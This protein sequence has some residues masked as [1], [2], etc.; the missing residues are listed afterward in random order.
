[1]NLSKYAKEQTRDK[2]SKTLD[3]ES[4]PKFQPRHYKTLDVEPRTIDDEL[5]LANKTI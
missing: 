2:R 3:N 4:I 1:M 5:G